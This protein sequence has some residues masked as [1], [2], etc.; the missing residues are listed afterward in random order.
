PD[1]RIFVY[2]GE[3]QLVPAL[4]D[5]VASVIGDC[6]DRRGRCTVGLSGGSLVDFLT[7]GLAKSAIDWRRV[8]LFYCDERLVPLD[9]PERTHAQFAKS[10]LAPGTGASAARVLVVDASL[11]PEAA[12]KDYEEQL[13]AAGILDD[14]PDLMLLGLGPDGH[15]CSL[16]P[17]H[18]ALSEQRP[19]VA[20]VLD[21]PKPPPARV[22]CTL[23]LINRSGAVIFALTG[24]GKAAAVARL[25]GKA[26]SADGDGC[27]LPPSTRAPAS[28]VRPSRGRLFFLLDSEAA[29]EYSAE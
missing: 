19:G 26:D 21:S 9:D 28:L 3:A 24:R 29:A 12:A 11:A 10:L 17:D 23:P 7:R 8:T 15:T 16:F 22:T 14:G 18:I 1:K 25:L 20:A 13:R 6:L 4:A 27:P 2:P 5:L